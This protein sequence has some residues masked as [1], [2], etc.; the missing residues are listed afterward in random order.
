MKSKHKIA[1]TQYCIDQEIY[2]L[3]ELLK[4][5]QRLKQPVLNL[6]VL[7]PPVIQNRSSILTHPFKHRH[8][9]HWQPKVAKGCRGKSFTGCRGANEYVRL[10]APQFQ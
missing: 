7:H 2:T 8:F 1:F 10:Y 4:A 6:L 5:G 3:L 9:K